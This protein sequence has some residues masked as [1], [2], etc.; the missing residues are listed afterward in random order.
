M[1]ECI[2]LSA[3]STTFAACKM[4]RCSCLSNVQTWKQLWLRGHGV[5]TGA[6]VQTVQIS[7][8]KSIRNLFSDLSICPNP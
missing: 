3:V 4:D 1:S 5:N 8:K 6:T 7:Y 2:A